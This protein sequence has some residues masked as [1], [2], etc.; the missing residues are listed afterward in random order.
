MWVLDSIGYLY[1]VQTIMQFA[2]LLCM[3]SIRLGSEEIRKVFRILGGGLL[4]PPRV[5]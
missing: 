2:A 4:Q 1:H 5:R 3:A